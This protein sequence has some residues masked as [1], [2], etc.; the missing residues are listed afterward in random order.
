M[1]K[2][3]A[4][5]AIQF[6]AVATYSTIYTECDRILYYYNWGSLLGYFHI[7]CT[8]MYS[9]IVQTLELV[10]QLKTVC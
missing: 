9:C 2:I 5:W 4:F 7:P 3:S 6:S 1:K 10:E 8:W